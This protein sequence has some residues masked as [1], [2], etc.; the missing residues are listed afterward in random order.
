MGYL[1]AFLDCLSHSHYADMG[2]RCQLSCQRPH[3][4]LHPPHPPPAN[5]PLLLLKMQHTWITPQL[6]QLHGPN[7]IKQLEHLV[8]NHSSSKDKCGLNR[9]SHMEVQRVKGNGFRYYESMKKKKW[10][11]LFKQSGNVTLMFLQKNKPNGWDIEQDVSIVTSEVNLKLFA[12]RICQPLA[13][14]QNEL[15]N[16]GRWVSAQICTSVWQLYCHF[17]NYVF[18]LFEINT[19]WKRRFQRAGLY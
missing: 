2:D 13:N 18:K 7:L 5:H 14:W 1:A 15:G 6:S 16:V 11:V 3:H 19:L 12:Q 8:N 10:N 17:S 9:V 4:S